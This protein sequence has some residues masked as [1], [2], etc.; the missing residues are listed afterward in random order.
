MSNNP[1][2]FVHFWKELKRRNVLR[3]LAI[4]AGTAFIILEAA[5]IIFPR[6]GFPDWSIDLVLW[7]LIL[8]AIIN[9]FVAWVFDFT[10]QGIQKTKPSE[11]LTEV[12]KR[13]G[14]KG[15]KAATYLSLVV[16][17][18]LIV[19]NIVSGPKELRAG[20]IQSL[21]ILPFENY[22]GDDQLENM[23]AGMHS[24]LIG[25]MCRISGLRVIGKTSSRLYREVDMS[26]GDIADELNV[27]A[28][29]EATV[30]CLGD[31]VC[32][33]FRLVST[34]GEEE[35]LWVGD[36]KEDK[37]QI[38]NLYN[39]VTKQIAEEVLIELSTSEEQVLAK[40]RTADRDAIDAYIRSHTYWGDLSAEAFDKAEEFLILAIEKDPEWS[41][42]YAA[43][44]IV[45]TGRMQMGMVDTET[46]R[47]QISAN[48]DRARKLD[49]DFADS[50]FINGV[51]YSWPDW[52]WEKGEKEF[53]QALAINPNHVM[54]RMYYAHLLMILQRMDEALVQ[55]KL[56]L[57][58]D[59]KNP[60]LLTLY[61]VVLKGDNQHRAVMEYLE[62]ALYIDPDHTFTRSQ[63]G[64]AYYNLGEYE[65]HLEIQEASLI[66]RLGE[67][68]VPDLV[69]IFREEG[70]QASYQELANLWE[71]IHEGQ[72]IHPVFMS[73]RY[74]WAGEFEK[75]LDKLE[76]AY[77]AHNPN[78]AYI[79]I[80]SRYEALHDSTRFLEILDGMNLPPPRNQ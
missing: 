42:L 10:S 73:R 64:R 25:D 50:H 78:M 74:Y 57:D 5:T 24:I 63:L 23:V 33:Q 2:R 51:I 69:S 56:A 30:M 29:I 44:A 37:S 32:M 61:S 58:L 34:T 47:K 12:E 11:E 20:D 72:D 16:I 31:T 27:D 13:S 53:L 71:L 45:W 46:G 80:G 66:L 36:Y 77:Q 21:V 22:T 48:I 49:V 55:G 18:A 38:L 65:K 43:M 28:V 9:I 75:A 70:Q 26:A 35:Q 79:G 6:W 39:R 14:S 59:P 1:G 76:K 7:L 19:L 67:D 8:G 3:S 54:A 41:T 4:Y 40:D 17:V 62:K 15:W 68:K 60:L 52:D